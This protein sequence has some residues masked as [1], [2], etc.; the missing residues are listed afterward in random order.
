MGENGKKCLLTKLEHADANWILVLAGGFDI[1][2]LGATA[3]N[4]MMIPSG[5]SRK[6]LWLDDGMGVDCFG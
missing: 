3:T 2:S 6:E 1:L 5:N 4:R